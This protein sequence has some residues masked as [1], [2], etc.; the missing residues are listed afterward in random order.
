MSRV[1]CWRMGRN[2]KVWSIF[3]EFG[4]HIVRDGTY[5][6]LLVDCVYELWRDSISGLNST[7]HSTVTQRTEGDVTYIRSFPIAFTRNN[8]CLLRLSIVSSQLKESVILTKHAWKIQQGL[9]PLWFQI[10]ANEP[11]RTP[12]EE[13]PDA[14][15]ERWNGA[16][17]MSIL[18]HLIS[19]M[20]V[21]W[22]TSS[23][24]R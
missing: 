2:P 16:V 19:P 24:D 23:R 5:F 10:Q 17:W 14:P 15:A 11:N 12:F 7:T 21:M 18:W 9:S 8:C 20:I 22:E 4:H 13:D 6:W 3:L 1:N